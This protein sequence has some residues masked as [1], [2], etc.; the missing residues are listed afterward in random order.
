MISTEDLIHPGE[1]LLEEFMRPIGLS[2][3]RLAMDL[4]VPVKR[5][6]AV[7]RC[8]RPITADLALR[9]SKYFK[10]SV[11]FWVN[12]QNHYDL[13]VARMALE[14]EQKA[15]SRPRKVRC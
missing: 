8:R 2:Q 7:V 12:L 3:N 4:T 15:V 14:E 5:I 9:L 10:T 1:I 6:N 11:E 13:D